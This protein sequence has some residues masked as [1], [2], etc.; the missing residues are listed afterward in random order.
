MT[1]LSTLMRLWRCLALEF[2][3]IE[4]LVFLE[5]VQDNLVSNAKPFGNFFLANA[6][7]P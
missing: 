2:S 5:E 4:Y 3:T 7:L 6:L 1:E